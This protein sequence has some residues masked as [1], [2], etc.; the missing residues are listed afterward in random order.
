MRTMRKRVLALALSTAMALSMCVTTQAA[1]P[2]VT[3]TLDGQPLVLEAPAYVEDDRTQVPVSIAGALG[4]ELMEGANQAVFSA[5]GDSLLFT[6]GS[7]QAGDMAMD[8]AADL[9][10][11]V[12]YVPLAY[13]AS[14]SA[15]ASAGTAP[16]APPP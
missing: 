14:T 6:D 8:T 10:G 3:V 7:T 11:E 2:E 9:S 15:S 5:D 12:G 16:P 4:L 1:G 13:L